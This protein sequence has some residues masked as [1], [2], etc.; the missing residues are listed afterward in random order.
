MSARYFIVR[1]TEESGPYSV[2]ELK[3]LAVTGRLDRSDGLRRT[4]H[5]A[6]IAANRAR[7]LWPAPMEDVHFAELAPPPLPTMR[8]IAPKVPP[9]VPTVAQN[10]AC[11]VTQALEGL[12][13]SVLAF[14]LARWHLAWLA[15]AIPVQV[16]CTVRLCRA[17]RWTPRSTFW[18]AVGVATPGLNVFVLLWVMRRAQGVLRKVDTVKR[19][20]AA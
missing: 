3:T 9:P 13:A 1:E 2:S 15:V 16:G 4:D 18:T 20:S 7:N 14:A 8:P 5:H 11:A 17:L 10:E 12:Q 19:A 6:V